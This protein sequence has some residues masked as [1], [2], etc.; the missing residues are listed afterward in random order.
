[1]KIT[2]KTTLGGALTSTGVVLL[3]AVAFDWMPD[4]L[5]VAS[6]TLGFILTAVGTFIAGYYSKDKD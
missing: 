6:M 4:W 2:S 3:G 1:M 5:Q